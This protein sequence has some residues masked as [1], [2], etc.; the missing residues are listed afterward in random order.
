MLFFA[1]LIMLLFGACQREV[2]H[3]P[4]SIKDNSAAA[5]VREWLKV[6]ETNLIK[7]ES[8]VKLKNLREHLLL[9]ELR[10]EERF[11][12]EMVIVVPVN[13]GFVSAN[14]ANSNPINCL[15]LFET[16][17]GK[18]R[19]GNIVQYMP[20]NRAAENKIPVNTFYKFYNSGKIE[21]SRITFLTITDN[22]LY[23]MEYK[24]GNVFKFSTLYDKNA[25]TRHANPTEDDCIDWYLQTYE[26][27]VLVSESYVFTTCGGLYAEEGSGGGTG[28]GSGTGNEE[29]EATKSVWWT[30]T[31]NPDPNENGVGE[32]K[33]VETIKGKR[34]SSSPGGGYFTSIRH[35][36]SI[37]NFCS[38]SNPTDVWSETGN[39][40]WHSAQSAFSIVT[41]NLNY[42][43][44]SYPGIYN[45][46]TWTFSEVF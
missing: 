42:N 13:D 35:S 11:D 41:G 9:S 46:K 8:K 33:A 30:V 15:L 37:C 3:K 18:I 4:G 10:Y 28:G 38:S 5:R 12:G 31:E 17:K 32:I 1:A 19:K 25:A 2:L 16:A 40:V 21:D 23:E 39:T 26:N 22:F 34:N 44:R 27:G 14:N 36:W 29:L 24:K 45:T 20:V 7:P 43:G 6:Q